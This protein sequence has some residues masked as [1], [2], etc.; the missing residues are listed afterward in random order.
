[1]KKIIYVL[2]YIFSDSLYAD[3]ITNIETPKTKSPLEY[4]PQTYLIIAVWSMFVSLAT[5]KANSL[6][7]SS[8][9]Q[10]IALYF[11][12]CPSYICV[13]VIT[14]WI[15]EWSELSPLFTAITISLMAPMGND[16]IVFYRRWLKNKQIISPSG[17]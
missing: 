10:S 2:S 16:A 14:F 1:M 12:R 11:L 8:C 4:S 17:N 7:L 3:V 6:E 9:K 15:C 13:G 5:I